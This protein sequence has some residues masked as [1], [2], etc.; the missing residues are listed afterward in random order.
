LFIAHA[1]PFSEQGST[2]IVEC[3]DETWQKAAL[4]EK[5]SAEACDYL[6]NVFAEWLGGEPLLFRRSVRWTSFTHVKNERWH[7][8]RM[9]LIGDAAHAIHFSVGSGTVLAFEDAIALA[10]NLV[11]A[12]DPGAALD[13]FERARKP[14][15]EMFQTLEDTTVARLER[16]DKFIHLEPLELAYLL[17]S[18]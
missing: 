12:A 6:A 7:R 1:Y 17:L 3:P 13:S 2:F 18:R 16:M 14:V 8:E 11:A 5:S 15:L 10:E 4:G 9:V